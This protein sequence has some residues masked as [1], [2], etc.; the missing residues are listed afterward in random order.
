MALFSVENKD[1]WKWTLMIMQPELVTKE[2]VGE[3]I[4]TVKKKK[5]Q[6]RYRW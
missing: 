2:M 5:I 1:G 6:H 3:A 4:E